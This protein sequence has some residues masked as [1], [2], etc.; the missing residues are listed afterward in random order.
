[1]AQNLPPPPAVADAHQQG[2]V[3]AATQVAQA[4]SRRKCAEELYKS[5]PPLLTQEEFGQQE[6]HYFRVA[7]NNLAVPVGLAQSNA[8][9]NAQINALGA[10]LTNLA[11]QQQANLAQ[12][13]APINAQLNALGAQQANLANQQQAN[14]AQAIAPINAQLNALVAQVNTL[15]TH[16]NL[17]QAI[18]NLNARQINSTLVRGVEQL[19]EIQDAAGAVAPNYPATLQALNN[20]TDPQRQQL[21]QFYGRPANP[22]ITR[23]QRLKQ[24]F[25]IRS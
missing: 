16:A 17:A 9:I 12:A 7:N 11:N 2:P 15:P 25:G 23:E 18:H 3:T 6:L 5:K 20:L 19:E 10:Q 8:P 14:L 24:L 21:L 13:I 1:M 4:S 22:I